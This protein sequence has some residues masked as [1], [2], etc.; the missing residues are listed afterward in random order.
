MNEEFDRKEAIVDIPIYEELQASFLDYAV[1]VV[2]SRA[3]PDVRDGLKPVHRRILYAMDKLGYVYNKP[4]H[5]S[6]SVVGE[7]L[8]KYHPHGDQAVYQTMVGMVQDF[9][10]RYPLLDGQGNWG[11]VDG[12]SAAAMRYT[13]VRMKKICQEILSDISKDTVTFVPNFDESTIEPTVLPSKIPNLLI[14]GTAGIAVGMATSV[15]PHNFNEIFDALIAVIENEN[16][17]DLELLNYVK[18]P[19]F[20]CGGVICGRGG[21]VKAYLEGR[22][23]FIVRGVMTVEETQKSSAIIVTELP[24]QVIKSDLIKHIANLVR[25]KIIDGISNIRDESNKKG[26][27]I[28]IELKRDASPETVM[29]LLFKHT[30]IQSNFSIMLLALHDNKPVLFTLKNAILAFINHRRDVL[31]RKLHYEREKARAHEHLLA[32]LEKISNHIEEAVKIISR[33][34]N[35]K[36]AEDHLRNIY[37]LT[38]LQVKAVLDLKLQRLTSLER[39]NLTNERNELLEKIDQ[40]NLILSDKKKLDE[41]I[42]K[43]FRYLKE[44]YGDER[45]TIINDCAIEGFDASAFIED[46][47]VVITLTKRGYLKRV[48]LSIYEVQR[49]GGKGKMAMTSLEDSDDV[50]QDLFITRNHDEMLFFTSLGRVYSCNVYEVPESSRTAKGRAVVNLLPLVENERIVKLLCTR[51]LDGLSLVMVTKNGVV[52][53]TDANQFKKIRQ[54]GI[55]AI[56]LNEGDELAFCLLTSGKDSLIV[57]TKNGIGTRFLEKEVRSMG[58]QAAGVRGIR[59]KKGDFVVGVQ[60]IVEGERDI[61]FVTENGFGK[62]VSAKDFRI[63]HRGGMGVRTIPTDSRNGKVIGLA[64]LEDDVDVMLIDQNGKV[65]RISPQEVRVLGRQAKGVRLIRLGDGQKLSCVAAING[66]DQDD[67]QKRKEISDLQPEEEAEGPLVL[68]DENIKD[69]GEKHSAEEDFSDEN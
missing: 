27:R 67:A 8:A 38:S 66:N 35:S 46:D 36:I 62:R 60:A 16:F 48:Q 41:E 61:L 29:N 55:R 1:S 19:D 39:K 20:P 12:D 59:L 49:R 4:Y 40:F 54:T 5:K 34:E 24:Y 17:P 25:D 14:N 7:V 58:R 10:K 15:P 45:K 11:S 37:D 51:N 28:F 69:N 13:E 47:E 53:K 18:G 33:S 30:A 65:I 26:M 2:I 68:D 63:A 44:A 52:K 32:G 9:S 56:S 64:T 6:V 21:I 3:I 57:A 43:E 50:V 22:G 31:S 23:S 42:V